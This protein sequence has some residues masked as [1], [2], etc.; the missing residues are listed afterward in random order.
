MDKYNKSGMIKYCKGCNK[1]FITKSSAHKY[2]NEKCYQSLYKSSY[3]KKLNIVKKCII[4]QIEFKPKSIINK[5]CS[6]KC[7]K[8]NNPKYQKK[9]SQK[10]M[11]TK[12]ISN[13]YRTHKILKG[14][15]PYCR[16]E[17]GE[18][19]Q[20][21]HIIPKKKG[22]LYLQSNLIKICSYC[23]GSKNDS[24]LIEWANKKKYPLSIEMINIYHFNLKLHKYIL[25][26]QNTFF[27]KKRVTRKIIN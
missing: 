9:I 8:I 11:L 12:Y 14:Y 25:D 27:G 10:K 22:G 19:T 1:K 16:E 18:D 13:N 6:E 20:V 17:F 26:K 24:D 4:C 23:N 2:C 5:L 3:V 7:R 15:C 21:D